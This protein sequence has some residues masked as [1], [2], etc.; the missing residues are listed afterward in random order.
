M[1][2]M[3][4]LG[5][6]GDSAVKN[7]PARADDTGSIAGWTRSPGEGNSNPL[8]DSCLGNPMDRGD[9]YTTVHGVAKDRTQLSN[10]TETMGPSTPRIRAPL[11][12]LP[13]FL[14]QEDPL[15]KE[16][17]THS[18]ILVREIPW[19]EETGG[20]QSIRLQRVGHD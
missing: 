7:P 13:L 16:I 5:F 4:A 10:Q 3:G 18:R 19:T 17:A 9:W 1:L 2:V 8:Q 12:P 20:L 11:Q 6:P 15:E 14:G